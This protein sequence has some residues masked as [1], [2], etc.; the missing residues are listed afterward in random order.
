MQGGK[1]QVKWL[2]KK[3][4]SVYLIGEASYVFEG[5]YII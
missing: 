4:D 3:D 2:G 1:A 5:V